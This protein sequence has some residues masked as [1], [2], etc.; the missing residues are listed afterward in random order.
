MWLAGPMLVD[1]TAE[2]TNEVWSSDRRVTTPASH[3]E[4]S[5]GTDYYYGLS[6]HR[7]GTGLGSFHGL[8]MGR[9]WIVDA[10]LWIPAAWPPGLV[11]WRM[12]Q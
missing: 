1:W 12:E 2:V 8:G 3:S 11:R 6:V 9:L 10:W 4:V 5:A 7:E